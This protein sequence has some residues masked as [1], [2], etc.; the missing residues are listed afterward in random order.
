MAR[1]ATLHSGRNGRNGNFRAGHNDRSEEMKNA[2]HVDPALSKNNV[3]RSVGRNEKSFEDAELHFYEKHFSVGLYERNDRYV[4]NRHPEKQKTMKELYQD[5]RSAPEEVILQIGTRDQKVD[6]KLL[7]KIMMEQIRWEQKTFPQLHYLSYGLHLDEPNAAPHVHARRAWVAHDEKGFEIPN[8]RRALQEMEIERPDTTRK[9]GRYNNAKMTFTAACREHLQE[10]C[11]KNGL[12]IETEPREKGKSGRSLDQ[13]K[14]ETARQELNSIRSEAKKAKAEADASRQEIEG[15]EKK[16]KDLA[17]EV[18]REEIRGDERQMLAAL[19]RAAKEKPITEGFIDKKV[20]GY[21]VSAAWVDE[22]MRLAR[23][24]VDAAETIAEKDHQITE[25]SLTN[26]KL[27][28]ALSDARDELAREKEQAG[29]VFR[30][31][32]PFLEASPGLKENFIKQAEKEK[33]D[34]AVKVNGRVREDEDWQG[35]TESARKER[36][37]DHRFDEDWER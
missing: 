11:R 26:R 12:E 18:K 7:D 25:A 10:L 2:D 36:E 1:R 3:Y 33:E 17:A 22:S 20:I 5:K 13:L 14:T 35:L 37:A 28:F 30:E 29:A 15:L 31:A 8:E 4:R 9:E 32:L 21:K 6:P 23:I 27:Q 34:A 16:K 19:E 24:G